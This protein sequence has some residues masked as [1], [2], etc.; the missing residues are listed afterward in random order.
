[1]PSNKA[2]TPPA[3]LLRNPTF[4]PPKTAFYLRDEKNK[5]NTQNAF[6]L[7]KEI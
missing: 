4:S 2:E 6:T 1:M 3:T 7:A 5:L